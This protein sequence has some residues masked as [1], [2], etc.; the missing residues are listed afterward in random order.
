MPF[1]A[2]AA[3]YIA[4]ATTA[5]STGI[6]LY[7]QQQQAGNAERMANYNA[8]LQKQN[9]DVNARLAAYQADI[10]SRTAMAQ[11]QAQQNNAVTLENQATAAEAEAREKTRRMREEQES[12]LARQ[13]GQSAKSGVVNEGSPLLVLADTARLTERNIL[14]TTYQAELQRQDYLHRADAERYQS[15]FSLLDAQTQLY[16]GQ[17]AAANQRLAYRDAD[18]TRLAGKNKAGEYRA[19]SFGTLVSGIGSLATT[20]RRYF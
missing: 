5:A 9:A 13:R 16:Q 12:A 1:L 10:G 19:D 2:A 8:A 18:L 11:Y 6:S 14:D 20:S 3:P 7:S 15:G 17:A 4:L